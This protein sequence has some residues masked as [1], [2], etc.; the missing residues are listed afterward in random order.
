MAKRKINYRLVKTHRSYTVEEIA[1]RFGCHKNTVRNWQ[2]LGLK[3]VDDCRPVIFEGAVLAKFLQSQ[4]AQRKRPLAPGQIYCLTCRAPKAPAGE[5]VEYV[6]IT[7]ERGNL[8]GICPDCERLIHRLTSYA[9]LKA[10]SGG[11]SVSITQASPRIRET[12]NPPVNCDFNLTG[13]A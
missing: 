11:L 9:K 8:R 5:M 12:N 10:V 4:S 3:P 2:R 13:D 1:R 7:E 6:P